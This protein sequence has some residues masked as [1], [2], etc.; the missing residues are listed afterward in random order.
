LAQAISAQAIHSFRHPACRDKT[1]TEVLV[2]SA[3]GAEC[4][5]QMFPHEVQEVQGAADLHQWWEEEDPPDLNK[6]VVV[7]VYDLGDSKTIR[8]A[9]K[10]LKT[11]GTGAFHAGVEVFD[12][13]YSYGGGPPDEVGTGVFAHKP[14]AL[15]VHHFRQSINI[16]VTG[17][18][19]RMFFEMLETI[20]Q[21]W[22]VNDY[23][24]L[25]H[26]CCDFSDDMCVRLG[27]GHV[28]SWVTNL[29]DAGARIANAKHAAGR[30]LQNVKVIQYAKTL[31]A[32]Q[33]RACR[34]CVDY[35]ARGCTGLWD[36]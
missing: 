33:A 14:K 35:G 27:V 5:T 28:P 11:L 6:N 2:R 22:K 36:L 4:C 32:R 9:N 26:N 19:R 24:I 18:T 23:D 20:A 17:L 25:R 21:D 1:R 16:G 3:M 8:R 29:A 12:M 31:P 7:N 34:G 15:T 30:K 10:I 13:E